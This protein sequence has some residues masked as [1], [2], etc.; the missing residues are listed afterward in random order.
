MNRLSTLFSL[1]LFNSVSFSQ[2]SYCTSLE[3]AMIKPEKVTELDLSANG[4]TRFPEELTKLIHLQK[5]DFSDNLLGDLVVNG[6]YLPELTTLNLSRNPGINA[7]DVKG[8]EQAFPALTSLNLSN[9]SIKWVSVELSA[10]VHL[11]ELNLSENSIELLPEEIG[12]MPSLKSIDVSGNKMEETY[13]LVNAW[14]LRELD[15]SGNPRLNLDGLG[16]TLLFK[17]SLARLT[18]TPSGAKSIPAHFAL[19]PVKELTLKGGS[20]YSMNSKVCRSDSLTKVIFDNCDLGSPGSVYAWLNRCKA[21]DEVEFRNMN[22]PSLVSDITNV[23]EIRFNNCDFAAKYELAKIK[24]QIK[25]VAINCDIE[26]GDYL[27]N[28]KRIKLIAVS[29]GTLTDEMSENRLETI[30]PARSQVISVSGTK[31]ERVELDFST[32]DIP[33]EAFLTQE[34]NIYTGEVELRITE[35]K[36]PIVNALSGVPMVYN[37]GD[38]QEIFASSGMIDFR[39]YDE[40]GNE[41]KPNQDRLIRVELNDIQPATNSNLYVFN[42]TTNTWQEVG[43][44]NSTNFD[45]LRRAYMDSLNALP[46]SLFASIQISPIKMYF[47]FSRSRYDPYELE[48]NYIGNG[49]YDKKWYKHGKVIIE[50]ENN[51]QRWIADKKTWKIDTLI[52]PETE[53]LLKVIKKE[54]QKKQS[55]YSRKIFGRKFYSYLPSLIRDME[56]IP[57][58]DHDNYTLRFKYKSQMVNL[59]VYAAMGGSFSKIQQKEKK[60]YVTYKGLKNKEKKIKEDIEKREEKVIALRARIAREQK[61]QFQLRNPGFQNLIQQ[62]KLQFGLLSFGLVNCDFFMDNPPD[63]Y[64]AYDSVAVD[65]MGGFV[66]VPL[67]IR[68]VMVTNNAY[69]TTLSNNVPFYKAEGVQVIFFPVGKRELAVVQ[70]FSSLENGKVRPQVVRFSIEGLTSEQVALKVISL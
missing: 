10:L 23:K 68:N 41:L 22:I 38:R 55:L 1:L 28:S 44:P 31:S 49:R 66:K 32:Y 47:D 13:W 59:P 30:V 42:D 36:D 6:I 56:L 16:Y 69:L 43:S 26:S 4:Y 18:I 8:M 51:D 25:V 33:S 70:S 48:F 12:E 24:P 40:R 50:T 27:G 11:E 5:L 20:V 58:I 34:G 3:E 39:A 37:D 19:L 67:D 65:Q 54:W 17:N 45:S 14:S 57:N 29:S 60:N 53:D 7:M 46:D 64:L 9:N 62:E 21:V 52:T 35:Y 15:I 63:E 61:F 2:C